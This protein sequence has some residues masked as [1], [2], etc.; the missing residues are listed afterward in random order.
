VDSVDDK[1]DNAGQN[2][3][4]NANGGDASSEEYNVTNVPSELLTHSTW[5][6]DQGTLT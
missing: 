5:N 2:G 6:P 4:R 3:K 1:G